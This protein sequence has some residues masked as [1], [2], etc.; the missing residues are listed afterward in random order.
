MDALALNPLHTY[1]IDEGEQVQ[2]LPGTEQ[3][4]LAYCRR[5]AT[6]TLPS[7]RAE[8]A[9]VTFRHP[10]YE[11]LGSQTIK[12]WVSGDDRY[13]SC[14]NSHEQIERTFQIEPVNEFEATVSSDLVETDAGETVTFY[15]ETDV[16]TIVDS[17]RVNQDHEKIVP[18][19]IFRYK[20]PDSGSLYVTYVVMQN[21]RTLDRTIEP[22][23]F[24]FESGKNEGYA[25]LTRLA[26]GRVSL[27]MGTEASW[28]R[29]VLPSSLTGTYV[30]VDAN[31]ETFTLLPPTQQ[32]LKRV[33]ISERPIE[34]VT[35]L[36]SL[37]LSKQYGTVVE[38]WGSVRRP[39]T[40]RLM[41]S[42]TRAM[43]TKL[44]TYETSGKTSHLD[45][46][47]TQ[48]L[49]ELLSKV[50]RGSKSETALRHGTLSLYEHLQEQQFEV[51]VEP[52]NQY[53]HLIDM[54]T[55]Q[56]YAIDLVKFEEV[57]KV[58]VRYN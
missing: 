22:G 45:G 25:F 32:L 5:Q 18:E 20:T 51:W 21:G 2:F 10:L 37:A 14:S 41:S 30:H 8:V 39:M 38:V 23:L 47:S 4:L 6:E 13:L 3:R 31:D 46:P 29:T 58:S 40:T 57:L 33:V 36:T 44:A 12:Y 53:V 56:T 48:D 1:A 7:R 15:R 35:S 55:K 34:D 28:E 19:S 49:F 9:A 52:G 16:E 42:S 43:K 54:K 50:T 11:E 26:D 27:Q 24:V 17:F